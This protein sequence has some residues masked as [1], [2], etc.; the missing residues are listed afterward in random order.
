MAGLSAAAP[1]AVA[2]VVL[3]ECSGGNGGTAQEAQPSPAPRPA[4]G[5]AKVTDKTLGEALGK[6]AFRGTGSS[7]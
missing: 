2:G 1:A 5:T 3:I 6:F 4:A 7:G